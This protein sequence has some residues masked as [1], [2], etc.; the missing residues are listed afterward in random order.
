MAQKLSTQLHNHGC[1]LGT[2]EFRRILVAVKQEL[3]PDWSDEHL[4][5]TA[6]EAENYCAEVLRRV[7]GRMPR[8]FILTQLLNVRKA[9]AH[10]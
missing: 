4:V 7:G 1:P 2:T 10:V 8:H 5:C 3:F 9:Q 6:D